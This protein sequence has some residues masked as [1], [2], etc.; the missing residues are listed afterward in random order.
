MLR[1]KVFANGQPAPDV[2][3][4]GA[5]LIGSDG[6]P[7]RADILY[8]EGE[9]RCFKRAQ[10][11]AAL[12]LLWPVKGYG[13]LMLETTR[14]VERE[15]PYN[16]HVELARGRLMKISQKR[17]DWGLYAYPDGADYYRRI[18][19]AK[20]RLVD[21][22]TAS[23]DEAASAAADD[24][25]AAAVPTGEELSLFHAELFV[26]HRK[27]AGQFVKRPLGVGVQMSRQDEAYRARV[28]EAFDFTV[29]PVRWRD[30]EPKQGIFRWEPM[31]LW[32]NWCGQH[33]IHVRG[34]PLI[35]LERSAIPDWV[36]GAESDYQR[37]RALLVD[38]AARTVKRFAHR[39]QSWEVVRGIHAFN[40]FHYTLEQLMDLTR[41][42]AQ[43]VKHNAPRSTALISIVIPWGEYY[44]RDPRTIPPSLFADMCVQSGFNFDAFGLHFQFGA[45]QEG[46][47]VRDMLQISALIDRFA[48]LGKPLHITAVQI[49]S[50]SVTG[51]GPAGTG[52][53]WKAPWSEA[54]QAE[55]L[56]AFYEI[57]FS[58]PFVET[59]AWRD[60][61]DG[62]GRILPSSG[63]LR[64]DLSLKP[65]YEALLDVR[66]TIVGDRPRMRGV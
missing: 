1:F 36:M 24:A 65:A 40:T 57:A 9:L 29:L 8:D 21:A 19:E 6:V 30:I 37:M 42:A 26:Q 18:D 45:P 20:A 25:I 43:V 3:L 55:W 58:K 17:E 38:H 4:D 41:S 59:V 35:T 28:G 62:P 64:E 10:G 14:L 48:N 53:I 47:L 54:I 61:C 44:A 63:L 22:L 31:D 34:A 60:L 46:M 7:L 66:H 50:S 23:T 12:C 16:L 5:F 15:T 51:D 32:V 49:P 52:G 39:V 13:Q 11:P 2:C 56:R 27:S 33:R